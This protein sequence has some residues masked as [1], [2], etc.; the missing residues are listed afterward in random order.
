MGAMCAGWAG[1]GVDLRGAGGGGRYLRGAKIRAHD[2]RGAY[3]ARGVVC[4][5]AGYAL[6][7]DARI[8]DKVGDGVIDKVNNHIEAI[9]GAKRDAVV[10]C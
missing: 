5:R 10:M 3:R 7:S 1:G 8:N 6:V 9:T 4:A 2:T